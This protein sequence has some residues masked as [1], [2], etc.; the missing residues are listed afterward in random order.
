[1]F[2]G[3]APSA[4]IARAMVGADLPEE[5]APRGGLGLDDA[6]VALALRELSV[7]SV[8][9]AIAIAAL[10]VRRGEIVGVAGGAG[11][12]QRELIAGAGGLVRARGRV[13]IGGREVAAGV[14]A[15]RAAGLAFIPE[16]R[17]AEGLIL[18]ASIEENLALGRLA[19]LSPGVA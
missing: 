9:G 15:R 3:D 16:D 19:S 17:H 2:A 5:R 12:G 6:R 11:N 7:E 8:L 4:D 14:A 18:D 13:A 10:E 1:T